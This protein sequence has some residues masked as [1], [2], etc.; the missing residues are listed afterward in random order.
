MVIAE[1]SKKIEGLSDEFAQIKREIQDDTLD[2]DK[3]VKMTQE[4][5]KYNQNLQELE[6][7]SK[8]RNQIESDFKKAARERN[9]ILLELFNA[10]KGEIQK[11]NESQSE[12]KIT[13]DFKGD[14]EDFKAEMK[15]DFKG[16]KITDV[17]YQSLCNKFRDYVELI[18]DWILY[19]GEK[20]RKIITNSEYAKLDEKLQNQYPEL[21]QKQVQNKVQIYY[22]GKLLRH[23]SIG[24]RASALILFIL[25][26]SNNDI[27]LID[28]PEDDLDNK[29]IYDE[30]I[31][32][33]VKKKQDMQFIFATH[34][35]NIP[36]L[37]DAER[38]F[39]VEYQDT[40]IDISQ[41]NIDLQ[42]T[43]K[44]IVDIM[45]GGKDAFDKRQLIY[46]SWN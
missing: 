44:H 29:I 11:I 22:H 45:E 37:G 21:L 34:N 24:Q 19:D 40:K 39:V 9:D 6:K 31:T 42:S 4:L 10:Y 2:P 30:V 1:L 43:H 27:I 32:A 33:I 3:F 5:E 8:S 38:I 13:I 12:L 28:Q 18:E 20:I 14:R 46:T 25:M 23:H 35:A 26:Q 17:K 36:V 7:Q 15:K 41:G 16:S